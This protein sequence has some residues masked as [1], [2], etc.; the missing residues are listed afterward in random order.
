MLTT[1]R[2]VL[3]GGAATLALVPGCGPKG[4]NQGA[5]SANNAQLGASM[6]QIATDFLKLSP[7][8]CTSLAVTEAQAGGRFMDRLSDASKAGLETLKQTLQQS[9]R[10]LSGFDRNSLDHADKVS[11]DV[12]TTDYNNQLACLQWEVGGGASV[13]YVVSQL[14]GAYQQAPDFLDSQHQITN[15]ETADAYV[16]RLSAFARELDQETQRISEDQAAGVTPPDFVIRA[17]TTLLDGLASTSPDSIVLVDSLKRRLPGV[18]EI[19]TADRNTLISQAKDVVSQKILPAMRRQSAALKALLP[20]ARHDAGLWALPHGDEMYAAALKQQT[21]T[22]MTPDEVH[23]MGLD[24][25]SSLQSQMDVILKSQGMTHGAVGERIQALFQRPDQLYANTDA[26]RQQCLDYLNGL[27]QAIR[28]RCP[29]KFNTLA[30]A[31]LQIKRV[32]AYTEQSAPGGY[33]NGAALDGSRPGSYYI[34][35]R[36]M[37]ELPKFTLKTL[38]YHEGIPGHHWQISIQ[39]ESHGLPFI[40]RALEGFNAYA[41]G[42]AL[43]AEQLADEMGFYQNDA[44]GRLGYLKDACFRASRL[45]V[46]TGMHAKR[47][48]REDAIHTMNSALGEKIA[49]TTTEIERY[50]VWPGQACGYMV[51]KQTLLRLRA[52]AQQSMGA[53]FD[54]KAFHDCLLTNGSTPLTVTE[55][56]VNDW[57]AG[58]HA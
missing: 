20:H 28:A 24:L 35:M 47:M 32:P 55:T 44:F 41:E 42:W 10:T 5:S 18:H 19:S 36:D 7:E 21:T 53:H 6:D 43:Y 48:S 40:R 31:D 45:V 30:H 54:I 1:R 56:I 3:A 52:H 51:G 16:T 17:A 11:V 13:P 2:G 37:N 12:L 57:A 8:T 15:R 39:Q 49:T 23:K 14:T 27:V 34:N 26:G 4:A 29:E 25:V 33:Y 9:V 58:A 38:T 50:C 22:T 46:D